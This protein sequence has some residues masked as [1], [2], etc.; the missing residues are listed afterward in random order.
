MASR[1]RRLSVSV[2]MAA[3]A[4]VAGG[5]RLD[6]VPRPRFPQVEQASEAMQN[7]GER[8]RQHQQCMQASKSADE[9]VGCMKAARWLFVAHGAVFPEPECWE[10]RERHEMD[11]L[12]QQCFV[13]DADHR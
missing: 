9:L 1:R 10:A 4:V 2:A 8:Y 7:G 5:C 6:D 12:G 3:L 11:R 13:R